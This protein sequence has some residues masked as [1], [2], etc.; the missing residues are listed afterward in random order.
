MSTHAEYASED[1]SILKTIN[2]ALNELSLLEDSGK[3]QVGLYCN[4]TQ[5]MCLYESKCTLTICCNA[6]L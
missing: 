1:I 4:K 5:K 2:K 3:I 6:N